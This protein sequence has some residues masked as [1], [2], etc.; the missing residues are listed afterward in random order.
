[1]DALDLSLEAGPPRQQLSA[2][3]EGAECI[4][5]AVSISELRGTGAT[6]MWLFWR[7]LR[8]GSFRCRMEKFISW[9][10]IYF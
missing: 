8:T 3:I 4:H 5:I 9:S 1:V 7:L 2:E 6:S 10:K